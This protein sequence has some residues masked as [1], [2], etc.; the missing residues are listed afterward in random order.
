MECVEIWW[1]STCFGAHIME[2]VD[3]CWQRRSSGVH[4]PESLNQLIKYLPAQ[5]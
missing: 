5:E 2:C 4:I 3:S 1:E